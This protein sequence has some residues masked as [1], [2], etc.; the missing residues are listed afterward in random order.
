MF[1]AK[2]CPHPDC[3]RGRGDHDRPYRFGRHPTVYLT[4]RDFGRLLLFRDR[5]G[6]AA[7]ARR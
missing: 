2:A 7:A 4:A 1:E 5:R 3:R 6:E